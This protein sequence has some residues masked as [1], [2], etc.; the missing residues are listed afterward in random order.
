MWNNEIIYRKY[1]SKPPIIKCNSCWY[2]W[3]PK[4]HQNIL[5]DII[6]VCLLLIW[7]FWLIFLLMRLIFKKDYWICPKCKSKLLEII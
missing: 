2:T 5:V 6:F 7:V 4:L 3:K 1:F